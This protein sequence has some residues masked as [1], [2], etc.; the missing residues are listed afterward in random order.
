MQAVQEVMLYL[1]REGYLDVEDDARSDEV[2]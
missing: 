2:A 1:L